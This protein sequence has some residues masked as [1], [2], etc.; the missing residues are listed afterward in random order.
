MTPHLLEVLHL[1]DVGHNMIRRY[2]LTGGS[3]WRWLADDELCP[4]RR[5]LL[6][7]ARRGYIASAEK[8]PGTFPLNEVVYAITD[9]GR[10]VLDRECY[11][12]FGN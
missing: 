6:G 4:L 10:R 5:G 12:Q 3:E 11:K 8:A 9:R 2:T 1:M 7:M